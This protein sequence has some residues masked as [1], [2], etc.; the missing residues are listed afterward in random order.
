MDKTMTRFLAILAAL[1]CAASAQTY[2]TVTADTNNVIRTNF[3]LPFNSLQN[4][5]SA[6]A[7]PASAFQPA[8]AALTNLAN[9]DGSA[10]TNI[11]GTANPTGDGSALTNIEITNIVGVLSTAQG[12]TGAT[13]ASA[14]LVNLLPA[15]TSNASKVLSVNT[16]ETGV[17]WIAVA[18]G[19][20]GVTNIDVSGG[21]TGLTFS[22]GP[23][24]TGG[25]ITMGG[26]LGLSNGGTGATNA[27]EAAALIF[28][29]NFSETNVGSTHSF[30]GT[31]NTSTAGSAGGIGIGTGNTVDGSL[32]VVIGTS[33]TVTGA[34]GVAIGGESSAGAQGVG[35]GYFALSSGSGGIAIGSSAF[36]TNNNSV[37][38]GTLSSAKNG[39]VAIGYY[40]EADGTSGGGVAI[41]QEAVATNNGVA[42]GRDALVYSTGAA[43]GRS[44][45]ARNGFAGGGYAYALG[46]N[47]VQLGDGYN[48][49]SETIQFR[50]AGLVDTNEWAALATSTTLGHG[51]M[52]AT[53]ATNA[54]TNTNA[55][56]PNA[57]MLVVDGTNNYYLPLWQ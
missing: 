14:A 50:G 16:N 21:T 8:S 32:A 1:T 10:L 18:G 47:S 20:G 56:T 48:N 23:I 29:D 33:N 45:Q 38:I 31:N 5:G 35:L 19:G 37:A 15:Y 24:T 27:L 3:V 42:I 22:G 36:S 30:L 51:N 12:G 41:G 26:A 13:N 4:I 25:T 52:K 44:A 57:W 34:D 53:V 28:V 9:G 39:N 11:S 2:R 43:I 6:A 49:T 40:A 46:T 55:P 7:S 17:E 54:P